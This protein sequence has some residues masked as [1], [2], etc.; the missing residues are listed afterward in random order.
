MSPEEFARTKPSAPTDQPRD[1]SASIAVKVGGGLAAIGGWALGMYA[2]ANLLIPLLATA[3]VW[4]LGKRLFD[5]Q[6][7]NILGAFCVQ[8]GHLIWFA[9]GM[10]ITR[11]LAPAAIDVAWY[12]IGLAWLL[13]KPGRAPLWFLAIYQVLSLPYNVYTF[14]HADLAGAADKALLVHIVWRSLALFYMGRLY[15][16]LGKQPADA[17][18]VR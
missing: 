17:E 7:R 2:G 11:Q 10:L 6:R 12:T 14:A 5:A 3:V 18:T 9:A 8:G 1:E 13:A 4:A 15:Y 16:L